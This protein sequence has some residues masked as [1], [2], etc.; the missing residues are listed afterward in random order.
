MSLREQAAAD[1][2]TIVEDLDGF[3][4]PITVTDPFG[5]TAALR[6]LSTDIGHT[7]DPETGVAVSGRRASIAIAIASLTAAGL[8]IPRGIADASSKP[9]V[10]VFNDIGG[11]AHTFKVCEAM[12]DRAIGVVTCLLATYKV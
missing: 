8:G 6:G 10:I 9:W 1:L 4:W 3:G 5:I 12:P 2:K 11:I 7:I